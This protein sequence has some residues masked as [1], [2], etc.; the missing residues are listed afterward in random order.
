MAA[1]LRQAPPFGYLIQSLLARSYTRPIVVALLVLAVKK[2]DKSILALGI[3]LCFRLAMALG[4]KRRVDLRHWYDL[5]LLGLHFSALMHP[6]VGRLHPL[7]IL[8]L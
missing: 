6:M 2:R 5:A 4:V 7:K 1:D 3:S 8:D